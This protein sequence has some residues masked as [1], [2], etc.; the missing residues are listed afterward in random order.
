ME[1]SNIND[2]DRLIRERR[3]ELIRRMTRSYN[4]NR[5]KIEG[6]PNQPELSQSDKRKR[7]LADLQSR[8]SSWKGLESFDNSIFEND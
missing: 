8:S 6:K 3:I 4:K 5:N 2:K 7:K 1:T